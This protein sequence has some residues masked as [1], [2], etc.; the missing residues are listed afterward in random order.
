MDKGDERI[1]GYP[2]IFILNESHNIL[3]FIVFLLQFESRYPL[4]RP[5]HPLGRIFTFIVGQTQRCGSHSFHP[6]YNVT[7]VSS[8]NGVKKD[9]ED[10]AKAILI[11]DNLNANLMIRAEMSHSVLTFK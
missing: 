4:G 1:F 10:L 11:G 2:L 9:K 7:L 5:W 3:N 6:I 8:T